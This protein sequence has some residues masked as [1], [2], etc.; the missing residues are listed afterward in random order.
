MSQDQEQIRIAISSARR[1]LL[2][3]LQAAFGHT[4][5]WKGVRSRVLKVF[6]RDGLERLVNPDDDIQAV[7]GV[8]NGE[9]KE[10]P[11]H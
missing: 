4:P 2:D 7:N 9:D 5:A 11:A 6:G 1:Q 8:D 10:T 3:L